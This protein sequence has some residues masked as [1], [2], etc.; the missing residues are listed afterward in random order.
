M[1]IPIGGLAEI[2]LVILKK[3]IE[4]SNPKSNTDIIISLDIKWTKIPTK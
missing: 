2:C 3:K 1:A 4:I